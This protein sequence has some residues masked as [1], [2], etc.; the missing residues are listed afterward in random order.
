MILREFEVLLQ[1]VAKE[2]PRFSTY[3]G[4]IRT[5][6]PKRT[7]AFE[8]TLFSLILP[9]CPFEPF[10]GPLK[11]TLEFHLKGPKIKVREKPFV[12]PDIDNYVKAV[13]DAM[14]PKKTECFA[15][16]WEDDA[17]IVELVAKKVYAEQQPKILIK[18]EAV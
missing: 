8:N 13:C 12:R 18:I 16:M 17:Q 7:R 11:L 1:P 5:Y 6:T 10:T 2:R 4:S 3:K 14:N 15:G 9:H